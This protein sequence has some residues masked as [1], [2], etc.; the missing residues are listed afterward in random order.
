MMQNMKKIFV[1]AFTGMRSVSVTE[2]CQ[3]ID[4]LR[5]CGSGGTEEPTKEEVI[6]D[7]FAF[8]ISLVHLV[9]CHDS[10]HFVLE[11]HAFLIKVEDLL[12]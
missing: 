6:F 1:L 7:C 9:W 12:S 5:V 8:S 2:N 10:L 3:L 4:W 11:F